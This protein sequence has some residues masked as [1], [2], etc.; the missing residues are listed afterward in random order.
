MYVVLTYTL[1]S[2]GKNTSYYNECQMP[3][4]ASFI[5]LRQID[6]GEMCLVDRIEKIDPLLSNIL[7]L[8][9]RVGKLWNA[10]FCT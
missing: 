7:L 10:V 4:V 8:D 1:K 2:S 5:L 3:K 6:G 9:M